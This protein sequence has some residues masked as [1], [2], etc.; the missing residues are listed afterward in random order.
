MSNKRKKS[1]V[2]PPTPTAAVSGHGTDQQDP[3]A[4]E[5]V[6]G[7]TI[8]ERMCCELTDADLESF[9]PKERARWAELEEEERTIEANVGEST[10]QEPNAETQA[11]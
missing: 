10:K 7:K 8:A 5:T 11:A 3:A 2:R 6:E 9:T 1:T 4:D